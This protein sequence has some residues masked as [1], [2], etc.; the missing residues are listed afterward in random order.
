MAFSNH[1]GMFKINQVDPRMRAATVKSKMRSRK[2]KGLGCGF[3]CFAL[4]T[5]LPPLAAFAFGSPA[6]CF[7]GITDKIMG[8]GYTT[9]G[10]ERWSSVLILAFYASLL[11]IRSC[12]THRWRKTHIN[13]PTTPM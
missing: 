8:D 13:K 4:T 5:L 12:R 9:H 11:R 2:F 3:S 1:G 6:L 10:I 7:V